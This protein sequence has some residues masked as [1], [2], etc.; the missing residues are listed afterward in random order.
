MPALMRSKKRSTP[1]STSSSIA[2]MFSE[3]SG[4]LVVTRTLI[5]ILQMIRHAGNDYIRLEEKRAFQHQRGLV[6][7]KMLPPP[8][9]NELRQYHRDHL[10][11]VYFHSAIQV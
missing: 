11:G 1:I 9:G 2:A 10:I 5:Q 8:A 4:L 7:Q 6:V 3:L